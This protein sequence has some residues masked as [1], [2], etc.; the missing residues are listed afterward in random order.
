MC[1]VHY[2]QFKKCFLTYK[3]NQNIRK[4]FIISKYSSKKTA[5]DAAVLWYIKKLTEEEIENYRKKYEEQ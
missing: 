4:R 2:Y 3:L 5:F 1:A